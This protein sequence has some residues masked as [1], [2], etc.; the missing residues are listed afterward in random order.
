MGQLAT[1]AAAFA[2]V[3]VWLYHLGFFR[4]WRRAKETDAATVNLLSRIGAPVRIDVP[5][6]TQTAA[7][8]VVRSSVRGSYR[9]KK[10]PITC[11]A[12]LDPDHED[13]V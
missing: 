12:P 11:P 7:L 8:A 2:L 10:T 4:G 3:S 6:L 1:V 5:P 13:G 9:A